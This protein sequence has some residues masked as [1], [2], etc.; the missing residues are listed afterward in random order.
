M[1]SKFN[2]DTVFISLQTMLRLNFYAADFRGHFDEIVYSACAYNTVLFNPGA[3]RFLVSGLMFSISRAGSELA[4]LVAV[5]YSVRH[6]AI[7]NLRTP[8]E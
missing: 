6:R 4:C 3:S 2:L 5:F 8:E 1:G 7:T